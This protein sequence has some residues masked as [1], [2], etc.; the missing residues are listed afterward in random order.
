[1]RPTLILMART[2]KLGRGKRRLAA[3]IG[4]VAASRFYRTCLETTLRRLGA[5]PRWRL[6]IAVTPDADWR[7][8]CWQRF[9][10][11]CGAALKPQGQGDL[12]TRMHRLLCDEGTP[13]LLMGSDIPGVVPKDIAGA[14][15]TL[16]GADAVFGPAEDG[17]FWLVGMKRPK[18]LQPFENV[19]WSSRYTLTDTLENFRG[20]EVG[21]APLLADVD[22]EA[23]YLRLRRGAERL[24]PPRRL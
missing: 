2:P 19:R 5:D 24:V 9:A 14:F 10:A 3:E 7:A 1:M 12:G 6:L 17:G 8:P 13:S 16:A 11:E 18:R 4:H 15:K 21:F 20:T 22:T 23:A